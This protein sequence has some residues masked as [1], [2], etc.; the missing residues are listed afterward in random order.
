MAV[1]KKSP[2]GT[3]R[4][5]SVGSQEQ[6][7]AGLDRDVGPLQAAFAPELPDAVVVVDARHGDCPNGVVEVCVGDDA[8]TMPATVSPTLSTDVTS[9]SIGEREAVSWFSTGESLTPLTVIVA[10]PSS[11]LKN[12]APPLSCGAGRLAR[13]IATRLI[14]RP[15]G[16]RGCA[17]EV[18]VRHEAD[19]IARAQ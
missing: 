11:A 7:L 19:R 9:S 16:E 13:L 18:G 3:K 4:T 8:P 12:V 6:S 17:G 2:S 1:P 14:P 5:R 10:V 15:V